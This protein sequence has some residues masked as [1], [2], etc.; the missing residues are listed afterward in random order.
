LAFASNIVRRVKKRFSLLFCDPVT[1]K[2]F[3]WLPGGRF[4]R[5]SPEKTKSVSLFQSPGRHRAEQNT[6]KGARNVMWTA[7]YIYLWTTI[8]YFTDIS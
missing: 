2:I 7:S 5:C 6:L 8:P 3:H 1:G 4:P